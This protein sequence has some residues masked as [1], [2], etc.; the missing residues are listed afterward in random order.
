MSTDTTVP[1]QESAE[2]GTVDHYDAHYDNFASNLY[3]EIRRETFGEDIGQNSW[4]TADEHRKF[5]A[6]LDLR[7]ESRVLEV[8]CGSGGPMLH[9]ARLT[10]CEA[11]GIDI[12]EQGIANANALAR[13]QGLSERVRFETQDASQDTCR[14]RS[15][16]HRAVRA[17]ASDWA[18][19]PG[20]S[21][22]RRVAW[23]RPRAARVHPPRTSC[24]ARLPGPP[25][26]PA[27]DAEDPGKRY[28]PSSSPLAAPR[29]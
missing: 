12:H 23:I 16:R 27:S 2:M 22:A 1:E 5:I 21:C 7:P 11:V 17:F 9:L 18:R 29:G 15:P 14:G 13:S 20:S 28:P 19:C 6:W 10:G 24:G 3:A 25:G 8:A 26:V 4:L